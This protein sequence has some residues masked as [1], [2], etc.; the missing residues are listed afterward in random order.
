[1]HSTKLRKVGGSVMLAVPPPILDALDLRVGASVDIRI[2]AGRLVVTPR[3]RASLTFDDLLAQCDETGPAEDGDRV[4]LEG[5]PIG[6]E[7]L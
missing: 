2:E 7:L 5:A 3:V 1:M 4:W 6:N